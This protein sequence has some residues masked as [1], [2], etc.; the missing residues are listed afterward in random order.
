MPGFTIPNVPD[1]DKTSTDQSEPDRGDFEALGDRRRGVVYNTSVLSNNLAVT[2]SSGMTVAIQGG[3]VFYQGSFYTVAAGN[4]TLDASEGSARFDLITVR[5]S[6]GVGTLTKIKGTASSSNP[7]FPTLP[8]TD[9]VL[10]AVYVASGVSSVTGTA[11]ID[12]RV[13]IMSSMTRVGAGAPASSLGNVGDL[14]INTTALT[15]VG[16]SQLYAKTGA[17]TWENIAEFAYTARNITVS[18][19]NPTGGTSGDIWVKVV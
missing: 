10:A 6:G 9:V 7:T 1:A 12:K 13:L 18:T 2:A 19:S 8:E 11:I 14:Y 17:T 4:L 5:I 16:R 3:E 15:E